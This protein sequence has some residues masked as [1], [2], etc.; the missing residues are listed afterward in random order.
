NFNDFYDPQIKRSNIASHLNQA[1][2]RLIE[3]DIRDRGLIENTFRQNKFDTVI[4]LAAMAGVRPSLLNPV[5]YQ[6]VNL[7]GTMNILEACR[8]SGVANYIFASSSSVYGN[9]RK[10]PFAETDAV[11]NPISPYAATKKSG[12]LMAYTYH[13]LYGIK[14]ACLRFFTVYGPRQRPEMAIHYFTDRIFQGLEIPMFGDGR[15]RRDY[16]YIDDIV[17]GIIAC[18]DAKYK[19]EIFN[20]GRSDTIELAELIKK[21]ERLAGHSAKIV[22]QSMQPGDVL[23]TYADITKATELLSYKPT[24]SID[25]GLE[26]FVRWY[27]ERQ[28][29]R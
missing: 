29:N 5:L 17:S 28:K 2:Y 26:N 4:H 12:E 21:I 18:I 25:K 8:D 27:A 22:R 16:T 11:D 20:L 23:Q 10:V 13:H 19:Y 6:E 14:T 24:T 3:G 9:N 1:E 7:I 15:S